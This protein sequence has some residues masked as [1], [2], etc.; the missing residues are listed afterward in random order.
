MKIL[1][2][3]NKYKEAG[4]ED[5]V[6]Q[7]E[8]DL[9]AR[10]RNIVETMVF[11]NGDIKTYWD[12]L[13]SGLRVIYNPV[14]ARQLESKVHEFD[15]EIIHV[16]NFVPLASP[17]IFFVAKRYRIPVV[18]TLHNFRL[19]CPSATLF[20]KNEIYEKSTR[21]VFPLGAVIKGVYRDSILQTAA[22]ALM[23]AVHSVIGTWKNRIALYVALTSFARK[24]FMDS[25]IG[26]PENKLV[27]KQNFIRDCG[28]GE[29]GRQDYYLFVGRLTE[30]KGIRTLLEATLLSDFKLVIIGEGPLSNVVTEAAKESSRITYLGFQDKSAVIAHMKRCKGLIFPS[31]WYEGLP[32]TLLEALCCGTIVIASKLGSMAEI[33][34]HGFNG[35]HFQAG[36]A[37]DLVSRIDEVNANPGY[38]KSLSAKARLTYLENYTPEKN[39]SMLMNIYN[40]AL[41]TVRKGQES[42]VYKPVQQGW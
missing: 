36:N 22:V 4:G 31:L 28:R 15:P 9:L 39:Y 41:T 34:E 18:L 25:A 16:H 5:A 14:S 38:F 24:K 32:I 8:A 2:I 26:I 35:L 30:E 10:N 1:L 37:K 23:T 6:F 21:S 42:V 20:H 11:D 33:I 12:K 40:R 3:H 7:A 17:S 13:L 29:I 19:I 27:V